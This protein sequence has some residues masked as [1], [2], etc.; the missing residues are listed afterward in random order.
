MTSSHIIIL[1][2]SS[3]RAV[4]ASSLCPIYCCYY[5]AFF[6]WFLY[7]SIICYFSTSTSLFIWRL[8]EKLSCVNLDLSFLR[9]RPS[10]A[11]KLL[12]NE[13]G[14]IP[15]IYFGGVIL[16]GFLV[17]AEFLSDSCWKTTVDLVGKELLSIALDTLSMTASI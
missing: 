11:I 15:T 8:F 17:I 16:S 9:S 13:N 2:S 1:G 12:F 14:F 5:F 3:G 4:V 6:R 7:S 10:P